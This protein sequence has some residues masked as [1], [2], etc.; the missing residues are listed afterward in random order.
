MPSTRGARIRTRH[1]TQESREPNAYAW[2]GPVTKHDGEHQSI[3]GSGRGTVTKAPKSPAHGSRSR[4][5]QWGSRGKAALLGGGA[6]AAAGLSIISFWDR[7]FEVESQIAQIQSVDVLG[8]STLSEFSALDAE[9]LAIDPATRP[10]GAGLAVSAAGSPSYGMT[11]VASQQ[12][13]SPLGGTTRSAEIMSSESVALPRLPTR[14]DTVHG[15]SEPPASPAPSPL[16]STLDGTEQTTSTQTPTPTPTPTPS[17]T[18]TPTPA[19]SPTASTQPPQ[20]PIRDILLETAVSH[21]ALNQYA[22]SV[23]D[24]KALDPPTSVQIINASDPVD[25]NDAE[26]VLKAEEV[27]NRLASDLSQVESQVI[28]GKLEPLGWTVGVNFTLKGYKDEPLLMTWSLVGVDQPS[29]WAAEKVAYRVAAT[30]PDDSGSA[31]I[32]VPDLKESGLY[33]IIVELALAEDPGLVVARGA[34]AALPNE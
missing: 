1:S 22:L 13:W 4:G 9:K 23:E 24:A 8:Y 28:D 18:A 2:C 6:L 34:P 3:R 19:P 30:T 32:W 15:A 11:A 25:P 31:K 21:P 16:P 14:M 17:P 27:A 10:V 12:L 33:N 20:R 29:S 26:V 5:I 7:L